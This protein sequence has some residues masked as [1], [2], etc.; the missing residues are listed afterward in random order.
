MGLSLVCE[1][2]DISLPGTGRF[3]CIH[4]TLKK[5]ESQYKGGSDADKAWEMFRSHLLYLS[6]GDKKRA[7]MLLSWLA[8]N[9]QHTGVKIRWAPIIVG[10]QGSREDLR[11]REGS[12][13]L[14][15]RLCKTDK[16][17][18]PYQKFQ[19]ICC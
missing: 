13:K 15:G 3:S 19:R 11:N 18:V 2:K 5:Y 17:K 6:K 8:H 12:E 14:F 7:D 1:R 9:I 10:G 16:N 4:L